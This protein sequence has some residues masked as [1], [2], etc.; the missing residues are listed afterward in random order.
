MECDLG[1]DCYVCKYV[2]RVCANGIY[3]VYVIYFWECC[4]GCVMY[5]MS[6]CVYFMCVVYVCA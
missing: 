6:V 5:V 2:L 1:N 4:V 3:G